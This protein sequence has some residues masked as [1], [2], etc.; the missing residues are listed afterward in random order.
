MIDSVTMYSDRAQGKSFRRLLQAL[1]FA[2]QGKTVFYFTHSV[3]LI[4]HYRASAVD[5]A[6]SYLTEDFF[7]SKHNEIEFDNGGK[8]V[9]C[10][11]DLDK[12]RG[13]HPEIIED[14]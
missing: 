5:I 11:P 13:L 7:I 1:I 10:L 3:G 14:D 8:V 12:T 9:F 2:S 6:R 4:S